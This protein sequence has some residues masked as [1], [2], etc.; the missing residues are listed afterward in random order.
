MP[1]ISAT[2]RRRLRLAFGSDSTSPP[3]RT[4]YRP[5]CKG[6]GPALAA[7]SASSFFAGI[8][9]AMLLVVIAGIAFSVGSEADSASPLEGA[10]GPLG[11]FDL[12]I[13]T[14]F[15]VATA[16]GLSRFAL[17][18]LSAHLAARVTSQLTVST[19]A[20]T[21]QDFATASWAEQ[22]RRKEADVHDLLLRHVNRTTSAM[23]V[24]ST[25]IST[26]FTLAAMLISA[27]VVDPI[28]AILLILTGGVLFVLIR[29]LTRTAKAI[30]RRQQEAGLSYGRRSLEAI[31]TS[32]EVR[33]FGVTQPVVDRL[34]RSTIAEARPIYLGIVLRQL[35]SSLYQLVTITM[36]LGGLFAVH[37]VFDRELASLG[38]IVVI[39]IRALTQAGGL[40]SAYHSLTETAPYLERLEAERATLRAS[41]PRSGDVPLAS[42]QR[43]AFEQV[44][45][46]YEP[47][48]PAIRDVSFEV[49]AGEAIGII[50]PSGSGK[51]TLIQL[52]LRLRD[53]DR[54]RYLIDQI[55]AEDIDD[56]SWFSQIAFVPQDS[57]LIDDTIA[58][59]IAFYRE[60]TR[61]DIVAAAKRAHIHD[62]IMAMPDGYDTGLGS[63]G[64][65]LSGGQR[66]RVSIAR[67]L[68]RRPAILV[69]DEPTS[70]LDM[71][72]ES[73][74]HETFS[75]LKHTVTIF[76]IAHRL[77]TL[78]TCD[79]IMVMGDGRLQ[80]FGTRDQLEA[81]SEFY[82][83]ALALSQIRS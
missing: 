28:A 83:D 38:A 2:A 71:R 11:A 43:L 48:R 17:Q 40:Q 62:E 21:F 4:I 77:S 56:E 13:E 57:H 59:N 50:G 8:A 61:D 34:T 3:L 55:D 33:A 75:E 19:R 30:S 35:V 15:L 69:L 7:M 52:L 74:V 29:P 76:A 42:H 18:T 10:L 6:K 67:A 54:G 31:G 5:F 73:L 37:T 63:R 58:A 41:P 51:S 46:A 65:A 39:L 32:L 23:G 24:M 44:T 64:G 80:A 60:V 49:A 45:Y 14:S 16:L 78:N 9:E 27:L 47:G 36:L 25:A 79:R 81:T 68:V 26:T 12:G 72:S 20:E 1:V 22:S 66:Q 82:R 70:A 53:P